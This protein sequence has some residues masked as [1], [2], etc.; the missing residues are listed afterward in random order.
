MIPRFKDLVKKGGISH[1]KTVVLNSIAVNN[2]RQMEEFAASGVPSLCE[3][4]YVA[5]RDAPSTSTKLV[6]KEK[7]GI[8]LNGAVGFNAGLL[9][10]SEEE[11]GRMLI[12]KLLRTGESAQSARIVKEQHDMEIAVN[13]WISSLEVKEGSDALVRGKS[14]TLVKSDAPMDPPTRCIIMERFVATL[15]ESPRTSFR[16]IFQQGRRIRAALELLHTNFIHMDVKPANVFISSAG[17][18]Y[19]GDFGSCTKEGA[20]VTSATRGMYV[21]NV[22]GQPAQKKFDF[23]MLGLTLLLAAMPVDE[24]SMLFDSDNGVVLRDEAVKRW[25]LIEHVELRAFIAELWGQD[26]DTSRVV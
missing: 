22:L 5:C 24:G 15:A 12:V 2:F 11:T 23:F 10:A 25:K 6:V 3:E 21:T 16:I 18:W 7:L 19:L 26:I 8:W 13:A 9:T 1:P 17:S 14:A 20:I 4:L